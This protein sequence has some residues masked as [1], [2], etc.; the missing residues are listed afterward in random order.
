M[1]NS[2]DGAEM[3][4]PNVA[5]VTP[6]TKTNLLRSSCVGCHSATD[7]T[8]WKDPIT[9]A[10]IVYNTSEPQFGTFDG[11]KYHGLAGGNFYW[12]Q[13]YGDGPDDPNRDNKGHN[14][15]FENPDD[16][17]V[18]TNNAPGNTKTGCTSTSCHSNLHSFVA[19]DESWGFAGRQGCTKC[20][21]AE[22]DKAPS[23][24]HH[25]S[26]SSDI[27]DR[28]PWYRFVAGHSASN[29]VK[30]IEDPNWQAFPSATEHN[31]YLG[32]QGNYSSTNMSLSSNAMSAFCCGCHGL[33][34]QQQDSDA[35]NIWIR[36]PADRA[37]P[38][39]GEYAGYIDAN[40]NPEAPVAR[41]D[42][43]TYT[44]ERVD[45]GDMV[46]CLSCHRAHGS[47]YSDMLRWNYDDKMK[48]GDVSQ[49]GGCFICHTMKN[50]TT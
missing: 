31:E 43:L 27:I 36:H 44:H 45:E 15:F 18:M 22:N 17:F 4:N 39:E 5:V 14:V 23:G 9:N 48:A 47:P 46:M 28:K 3:Q 26:V 10:P 40:Y 32:Y 8:T 21:M 19:E 30:G 24:Y 16:A 7:G 33:F 6:G 1:H 2:Q 12:V 29:G 38:N 35:P 49:T 25:A 50:G 37:L 11:E 41:P 34:H 20:H 13:H 42:F